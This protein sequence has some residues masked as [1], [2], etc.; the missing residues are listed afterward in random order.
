MVTTSWVATTKTRKVLHVPAEY[1]TL[2]AS[3]GVMGVIQGNELRARCPVPGHNDTNPSFSLNL[4]RGTWICFA[5]CGAGEFFR[6]VQLVQGCTPGE[7]RDWI[8]S[9]GKKASVQVLSEHLNNLLNPDDDPDY[10][11]EDMGWRAKY[12]LLDNKIMPL[13][14]M[15]RGFKWSTVNHWEI[16]YDPVWDAVIVPVNWKGELVGTITRNKHPELPKYVNS[17]NLPRAEMLFGDISGVKKE[18]IL[19][20][21][22]LDAIW[23]WQL[24][25]NAGGLLGDILTEGQAKFLTEMRF[26]EVILALDNDDAGQKGMRKAL[27][28]LRSHGWL[29]PQVTIIRFPGK[30]GEAGYKKDAQDCD[31]E[32]IDELVKTRENSLTL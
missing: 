22:V 9:N 11:P 21:G 30:P 2:V 18:I 3:L 16:K 15:E 24:G 8:S 14:F 17:K 13:W 12:R 26:A 4:E 7:A 1:A 19:V 27:N 10:L 5:G 23:L 32:E 31:P 20:E 25:Y 28:T 6:L 29:L